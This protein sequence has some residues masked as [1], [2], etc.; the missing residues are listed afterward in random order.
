MMMYI[1]FCY[2]L[3]FGFYLLSLKALIVSSINEEEACETNLAS[4]DHLHVQGQK[5]FS[6]KCHFCNY[7]FCNTSWYTKII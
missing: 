7:F 4:F 2:V 5:Q 3:F 1:M 6:S